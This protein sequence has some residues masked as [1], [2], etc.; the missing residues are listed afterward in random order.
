MYLSKLR[1]LNPFWHPPPDRRKLTTVDIDSQLP[2]QVNIAW[3]R[4][5]WAWSL[6]AWCKAYMLTN[7]S[8]YVTLILRKLTPIDLL[9]L[10]TILL[11]YS[12]ALASISTCLR[13]MSVKDILRV[14]NRFWQPFWYSYH[15]IWWSTTHQV[16]PTLP[17]YLALLVKS[18]LINSL[19]P[20]RVLTTYFWHCVGNA[21]QHGFWM[22]L[23]QA[24]STSKSA[25]KYSLGWCGSSSCSERRSSSETRS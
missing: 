19:V 5:S 12:I 22:A 4:P 7:L 11:T 18:P 23:W 6:Y 8:E 20:S 10:T 21:L 24:A 16:L 1:S 14:T 15:S 25:W 13:S 9:S 3:I 2:K 17:W